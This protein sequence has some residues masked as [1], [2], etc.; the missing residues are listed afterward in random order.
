LPDH[1]AGA[2]KMVELILSQ[3]QQDRVITLIPV[4]HDHFAGASKMIGNVTQI[5]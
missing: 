1:F 2:G 3:E 4:Q 5:S